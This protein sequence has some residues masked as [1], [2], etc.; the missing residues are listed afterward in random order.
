MG[1]VIDLSSHEKQLIQGLHVL[2]DETRFKMFRLMQS[3]QE[4]CVSSIAA[5]L[6]IS[7]SAVSQ[8]FR[9]FES[10]GLVS[11]KRYGQKICYRLK[12]SDDLVQKLITF[13]DAR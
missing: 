3:G 12:E 10:A 11:K 1:Q 5:K 4:L 13:S 9:L 8:H 6:S 7:V 2:S